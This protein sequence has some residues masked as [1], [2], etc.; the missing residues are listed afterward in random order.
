MKKKFLGWHIDL[1]VEFLNTTAIACFGL[2]VIAPMI[3]FRAEFKFPE[4]AMS[5]D[6]PAVGSE[7][8]QSM[9]QDG[10]LSILFSWE[11]LTFDKDLSVI[12]SVIAAAQVIPW[13]FVGLSFVLH[14]CAHLLIRVKPSED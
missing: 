11:Q 4:G 10:E 13:E 2:A 7:K 8:M 6:L 12:E 9:L 3:D 14:L 5:D 1:F